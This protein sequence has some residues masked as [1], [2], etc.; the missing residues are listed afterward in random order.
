M[1]REKALPATFKEALKW[2]KEAANKGYGKAQFKL[3]VIYQNGRDVEQNIQTAIE[4]YY[5]A[6]QHD[7]AQAAY[8]LGTIYDQGFIDNSGRK[9]IDTNYV[10]AAKFY[11]T[12]VQ[13]DYNLAYAP[14][15]FLYEN[16]LGVPVDSERAMALYQ[17]STQV[18]AQIRLKALQKQQLC[19]QTATTKLFSVAIACTNREILDQQ[20][21]AQNIIAIDERS[22]PW[23]DT[24]FSG[25]VIRGSSELTV[26]YTKDNRFASARYTYIGRSNPQL[27]ADISTQL[28]H[29][30]G[31]P[32]QQSGE[33]KQGKAS[34]QWLLQ[35]GIE[36]TVN[37]DW[38]DTT[39][40]VTY[41]FPE[42][43]PLVDKRE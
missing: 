8:Q 5:S 29:T 37:R 24:Y 42:H 39:T 7:D 43:L 40:F 25:A 30:Y 1:N 13:H 6:V 35:D 10:K 33:I 27:I 15:A 9:I 18:L 41:A 20:I 32:H 22:T 12:A 21:K 14:L 23:S 4:W 16:G 17:K 11:Q 28:S 31:Q 38:P 3:G 36:L 26:I 2:Y 19:L 34:F